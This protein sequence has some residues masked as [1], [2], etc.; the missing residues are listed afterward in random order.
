[1]GRVMAI[2]FPY[3]SARPKCFL[4]AKH[5]FIKTTLALLN[6][7]LSGRPGFQE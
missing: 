7:A 2:D 6:A 1:M 3:S 4:L 5:R